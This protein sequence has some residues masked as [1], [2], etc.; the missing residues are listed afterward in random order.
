M[1]GKLS[2]LNKK[3]IEKKDYSH[4]QRFS[5]LTEKIKIPLKFT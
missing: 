4:D 5:A 3:K 1:N 2:R